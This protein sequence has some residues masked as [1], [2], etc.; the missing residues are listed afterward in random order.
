MI[1]TPIFSEIDE[2]LIPETTLEKRIIRH[3][4]WRKGAIWG[5]PRFGHPEGKVL[6]HIEEVFENIEKLNINTESRCM[7]RFITL[8]HD[9]FKHQEHRGY[10]RDWSKHHAVIA[11][12]F[13]EQFTDNQ[14]ILDIIELHDEAYHIWKMQRQLF[15]QEAAQ[16][17]LNNLLHRLGNN[18]QLYYLFFKCDTQ[19]GDKTQVPVSW[20]EETIKGIE[21]VRF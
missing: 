16:K 21:I 12:Q 8:T 5:K 20:F 4:E 6:Y 1:T 10:P 17:R 7:L 11:R 2:R 15:Q 19:T 14:A 3:P 13:S 9:A 18:L